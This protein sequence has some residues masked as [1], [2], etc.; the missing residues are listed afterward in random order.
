MYY[1][2]WRITEAYLIGDSFKCPVMV[3]FLDR[4]KKPKSWIIFFMDFPMYYILYKDVQ[5]SK[6]Y[7]FTERHT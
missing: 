7:I 3:L 6:N 4:T 5:N 2:L 1:I